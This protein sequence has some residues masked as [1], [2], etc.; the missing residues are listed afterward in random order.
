MI[1]IFKVEA[2]KKWA[3]EYPILEAVINFYVL[4]LNEL[5]SIL[6]RSIYDKRL[7]A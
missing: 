2:T 6:I 3:A 5:I 7:S 1:K 4:V